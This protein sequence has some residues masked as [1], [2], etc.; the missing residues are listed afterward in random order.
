MVVEIS[1]NNQS[2]RIRII[3]CSRFGL[4]CPCDAVF[5][6]AVASP[7]ILELVALQ[8][9]WHYVEEMGTDTRP[10]EMGSNSCTHDASAQYR[11]R[12]K[13]FCH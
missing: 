10:S 3:K 4:E 7:G 2:R 11:S 1:G 8:V 6:K 5:G 13:T 12:V 9:G